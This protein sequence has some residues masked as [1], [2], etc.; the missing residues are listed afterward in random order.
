MRIARAPEQPAPR[1]AAAAASTGESTSS[2]ESLRIALGVDGKLYVGDAPVDDASLTSVG[3]D[4]LGG[5]DCRARAGEGGASRESNER[6]RASRCGEG[7]C[8]D[9]LV[10]RPLRLQPCPPSPSR[11]RPRVPP[12]EEALPDVRVKNIGFHIGGGPNDDASK[13]PFREAIA[14]HFDEFRGC[15]SKAQQPGRGGTFGVDLRI[16]AEGGSPKVT[17]P[18]DGDEGPGVSWLRLEGLRERSICETE[19]R[20]DLDQLLAR[21]R[22]GSRSLAN[23]AAW[24]I[25]TTSRHVRTIRRR[26]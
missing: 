15:Y 4:R 18:R 20:G 14:A 9:E 11:R 7:V 24:G 23:A 21:V 12:S 3:R 8:R 22:A 19:T 5:D 25:L 2:P 1:G 10:A 16:E 6:A 17:Q 13:A 26:R